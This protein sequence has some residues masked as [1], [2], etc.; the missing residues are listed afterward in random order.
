MKCF[1]CKSER[2]F[3]CYLCKNYFCCICDYSK[4]ISI[5]DF[6]EETSYVHEKCVVPKPPQQF[7]RYHSMGFGDNLSL[8][9]EKMIIPAG[10]VETTRT[11]MKF[12]TSLCIFQLEDKN[13]EIIF[14]HHQEHM[15]TMNKFFDSIKKN[16][17]ILLFYNRDED[18]F[19]LLK[20]DVLNIDN[21]SIVKAAERLFNRKF[22]SPSSLKKNIMPTFC[23]CSTVEKYVLNC[24]CTLMTD[25]DDDDE[26]RVIEWDHQ[27]PF[28]WV[29]LA[30]DM[31][32]SSP[33]YHLIV[34]SLFYYYHPSIKII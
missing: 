33:D 24:G 8:V 32:A 1:S 28:S 7:P 20:D 27:Q 10:C 9:L 13:K 15:T 25:D 12:I 34:K 22:L 17:N 14:S 3:K 18:S 11:D 29:S 16:F 6:Q 2:K 19:E 26:L 31:V 4:L 21:G 30:D 23:S 5:E